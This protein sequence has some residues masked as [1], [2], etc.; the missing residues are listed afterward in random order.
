MRADEE[1]LI[2]A[3]ASMLRAA[4]NGDAG[5][6]MAALAEGAS[7]DQSGQ[8]GHTALIVA[9]IFNHVDIASLLLAAG[10]NVR[11]QDS[12]GLTAREWADRRGSLEVAKLLLDASREEVV[13]EERRATP[14]RLRVEADEGNPETEANPT[15]QQLAPRMTKGQPSTKAQPQS[16]EVE[17]AP[18]KRNNNNQHLRPR[19]DGQSRMTL[20]GSLNFTSE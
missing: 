20:S 16:R 10:A 9:A 7:V 14:T 13:E 5:A 19:Q 11:L 17:D 3:G 2:S 18:A 8:G 1:N 12:L 6:V 4:S 15:L